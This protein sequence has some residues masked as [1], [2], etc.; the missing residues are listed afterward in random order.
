MGRQ[1]FMVFM[2]LLFAVELT[3]SVSAVD[4][5]VRWESG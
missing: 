2:V 5:T 4:T 1:Y 3:G